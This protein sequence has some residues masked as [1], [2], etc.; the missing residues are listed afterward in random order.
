M[1]DSFVAQTRISQQSSV[2]KYFNLDKIVTCT[3]LRRQMDDEIII[4]RLMMRSIFDDFNVSK[5]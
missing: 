1:N 3:K 5:L 2:E 4:Q